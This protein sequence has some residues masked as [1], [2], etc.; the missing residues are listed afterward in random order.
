MPRHSTVAPW[1]SAWQVLEY[2]LPSVLHTGDTTA[3]QTVPVFLTLLLLLLRSLRPPL[4]RAT[5]PPPDPQG[6]APVHATAWLPA[7]QRLL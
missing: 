7:K 1:D 6:Q 4:A 2:E 3:E 5:P